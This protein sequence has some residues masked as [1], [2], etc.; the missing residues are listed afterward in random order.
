[1]TQDRDYSLDDLWSLIED[2][3][4][5][6]LCTRDAEGGLRS[7]PMTTLRRRDADE[8]DI[9]FFT[10]NDA[11]PAQDIERD[12]TVNLAYASPSKDLYV[13]VGGQASI[14][15]DRAL[16]RELWTP[17]AKAWFPDGPE[18]PDLRLVQVRIEQA[19][20]WDIKESKPTQVF[21]MAKAALTGDRPDD[22]GRHGSVSVR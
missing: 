17:M 18:A 20:Y 21:L 6:M 19:D 12:G 16:M 22:L 13:S 7:R 2:V 10:A 8:R 14:V 15:T 5:A 11:P 3:R 4:F 9:W 1:M